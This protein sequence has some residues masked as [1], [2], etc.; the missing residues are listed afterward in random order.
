MRAVKIE[1]VSHSAMRKC[2]GQH[3]RYSFL[4]VQAHRCAHFFRSSGGDWRLKECL[5]H[6]VTAVPSGTRPRL[7]VDV[8]DGPT[9]SV[10]PAPTATRPDARS[11]WHAHVSQSHGH[12]CPRNHFSTSRS[13]PLALIAKLL[14]MQ[15]PTSRGLRGKWRVVALVTAR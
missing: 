3:R 4:S 11:E 12:P 9:G 15:R 5:I 6:S 8:S 14:L 1:E 7:R 10:V 2:E 13:P